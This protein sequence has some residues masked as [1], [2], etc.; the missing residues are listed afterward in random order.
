M[1]RI[2]IIAV[3]LLCGV[4]SATT[5]Y[6]A[7]SAGTFTGGTACNGQTAITPAT[8]SGTT[9]SAGDI[10]WI[11]GTITATSNTTPIT[12]LGNGSSGNP[13]LIN[14]DTGAILQAPYFS[15]STGAIFVSGRSYIVINGGTTC[16]RQN[17]ATV[18]CNGTIQN[19][20]NGTSLANHQTSYGVLLNGCTPGCIVENLNILNIYVNQGTA[21]SGTDVAGINTTGVRLTGSNTGAIVTGNIITTTSIGVQQDFGSVTSSNLTISHN[22]ISDMHWGVNIGAGNGNSDISLGN[23]IAY[24]EITNWTNW[25]CPANSGSNSPGCTDKADDIYHTDGIIVFNVASTVSTYTGTHHDNYIHGDLGSGSPTSFDYCAQNASCTLYNE[26]YVNT[27]FLQFGLAWLNTKQCSDKLYDST[28][29]G[30]NSNDIGVTFGTSTC[31]LAGSVGNA[32]IENNIIIAGFGLHDYSV[33]TTDV[34]TSDHNV[35]RTP[36]GGVPQMATNDSTFISFATWQSDGFDGNSSTATPNL[37]GSYIPQPTSSAIGRGANLFSTLAGNVLNTDAAGN[38]R[39][40]GACTPVPNTTG[41]WDAGAYQFTSGGTACGPPSYP[42]F[43]SSTTAV[44]Y[45]AS[46]PSFGSNTCDFTTV[47][48]AS[49]CGNLDGANTSATPTDFNTQ[50]VRVTDRSTNGNANSLWQTYDEPSVNAWNTD[51][52]AMLLTINGGG[53]FVFLWNTSTKTAQALCTSGSPPCATIVSFSNTTIWSYINNNHAW[54]VD[55]T[56]GPGIYVQDNTVTLTQGSGSVSTSNVFDFTNSQ[57]LMNTVNGYP[58]DPARIEPVLSWSGSGTQ[59]TFTVATGTNIYATNQTVLMSGFTG[60]GAAF[61][62]LTFTVLSS[63]TTSQFKVTS[64]VTGS[65]STGTATGTSFPLNQWTGALGVERDETTFTVPFSIKGGQGSGPYLARWLVGQ[66]GCR[67]YRT[68]IGN[69]TNNGTLL[70]TITDVPWNGPVPSVCPIGG[71]GGKHPLWLIHDINQPNPTHTEVSPTLSTFIYGT[72]FED[73]EFWDGTTNV[74]PCGVGA[75]NWKAGTVQSDG[76][77]VLPFGTG[78][79]NAGKFIYQIINTVGGT[80]GTS[81]PTWNQTPASDTVDGVSGITWRN[82]GVGAAQEYSC[83]GHKYKGYLG[84]AAGKNYSYHLYANPISP[85]LQLGPIGANSVG[86]Q[87]LGNTQGNTTDTNWIV[88]ASSSQGTNVDLLHGNLPGALYGELFFVAPPYCTPGVLNTVGCTLGQVRRANHGYN[89]GWS[90]SFDTRYGMCVVS[91]T[92]NYAMC[93]FDGFGQFGSRQGN[94]KCNI[95]GPNWSNTDNPTFAWTVGAYTLP[96]LGQV[97]PGNYIYKISSCSG[98]CTK[99]TTPPTWVQSSTVAGVG[100]FTDGTITWVA[101]P[102]ANTPANT[103]VANCRTEVFVAILN[104]TSAPGGGRGTVIQGNTVITGNT[105]IQ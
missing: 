8:F 58:T 3:L 30:I 26:L 44:N 83:A 24:N 54:S 47:Q 104:R 87:H 102:D 41:C 82:T 10:N 34:G 55:N 71:C 27:G 15:S 48:T 40:G 88:V 90:P 95:G 96:S 100:S 20:A 93:P 99:G 21:P 29:V 52:S 75:P 64:T 56:T 72:F 1:K 9:N 78:G 74:I 38:S 37:N 4:A 103:A 53:Q 17:S 7:Q 80:N 25:I 63:G 84:A 76:D 60:A 62:G 57:C 105:V 36:G 13:V 43:V 28:L 39:G 97:N 46:I 67:L 81:P 94:A 33:L 98:A 42:C 45:P 31:Q 14:F 70:G 35:F 101:A 18:A 86:D 68:D 73:D 66:P 11:C 65:S 61:N 6:V 51:D 23:V 16:G 69:V 49:T 59:V 79:T 19:T 32:V 22:V 92:G 77:R 85:Q 91:Q 50:L 12:V 2:L 89:T 5:R